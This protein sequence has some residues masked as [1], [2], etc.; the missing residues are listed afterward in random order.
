MNAKS[1]LLAASS[2]HDQRNLPM[3]VALSFAA[4]AVNATALAGC[5]RFVS[6]VTGTM[7][8]VGADYDSLRLLVDYGA[9]LAA[10][11]VGAMTSF[12]AIDGRRLQGKSPAV[13]FPLLLVASVLVVVGVAGVLGA[14]GP[15]GRTVETTGD[16]VML[17]L[18]AFA[19]GL[20][21]ASVATTSGMIVRTTHMTGPLTDLSIALA[22]YVSSGIPDDVRET[23]RKSL[24]LRGSKVMGF[25]LGAF[26]AAWFARRVEYAAFFL[27]A[28]FVAVAA[29]MLRAAVAHAQ[30]A[31]P[32]SVG[33][34][35]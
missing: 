10:F 3:W 20:Q 21:N 30:S 17:G 26:V 1:P 16:F 24:K 12:W 2:V 14:F 13:A 31:P 23:A 34:R 32:G 6:H 9:V 11:V 7:T 27:P 18:L 19:M 33:A 8:R 5:Q 4:G 35:S 25:I 29:F 15:F 28:L 22:A